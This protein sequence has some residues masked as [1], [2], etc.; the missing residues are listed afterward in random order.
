MIVILAYFFFI[1][2]MLII[3]GTFRG[4]A[5]GWRLFTP[6]FSVL[7]LI[8]SLLL[9]FCVRYVLSQQSTIMVDGNLLANSRILSSFFSGYWMPVTYYIAF[10]LIVLLVYR[11][12]K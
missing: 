7:S 10:A 5:A 2:P 11:T 1:L 8:H 12:N 9:Y 4:K 3:V 6:A